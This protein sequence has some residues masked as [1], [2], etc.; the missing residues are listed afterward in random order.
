M[1]DGTWLSLFKTLF[2]VR[3]QIFEYDK[4]YDV[5][6]DEELENFN[7]LKN[8]KQG[9]QQNE[10]SIK[11]SI[12]T[13]SLEKIDTK[14]SDIPFL[15]EVT[16]LSIDRNKERLQLYIPTKLIDIEKNILINSK[17]IKPYIIVSHIWGGV[18]DNMRYEFYKSFLNKNMNKNSELE[19]KYYKIKKI[20]K[21]YNI[22]Y[23]WWDILCI[24]YKNNEDVK[25]EIEKMSK[26]YENAYSTFILL[27][28]YY[29]F[30]SNNRNLQ[31]KKLGQSILTD[32]WCT[33]AWTLQ[34]GL[35]SWRPLI[36]FSNCAV[37]LWTFSNNV[38]KDYIRIDNLF[39]LSNKPK[40]TIQR[41]IQ[42]M[43][44]RDAK[45]EQDKVF[46]VRGLLIG[47]DDIKID[48]GKNIKELWCELFR[49]YIKSTN[50]IGNLSIIP[51][52]YNNCGSS[53]MNIGNIIDNKLIST[54]MKYLNRISIDRNILVLDD[55]IVS[56]ILLYSKKDKIIFNKRKI[57]IEEDIYKLLNDNTDY[58]HG[59][60]I[61]KNN[62]FRTPY[63]SFD[64]TKEYNIIE[65]KYI[66]NGII[67]NF[68]FICQKKK[69]NDFK[70]IMPINDIFE[71]E[72]IFKNNP[73][74]KNIKNQKVNIKLSD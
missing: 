11:N 46:S 19:K 63:I 45:K 22:K 15:T 32:K 58:C 47:A 29:D 23:V 72:N 35:L 39:Y 3:Q 25:I 36:V 49:N 7:K 10:L 4:D 28:S 31:L 53:W 73:N 34:E 54:E 8:T 70:F 62:I 55:V 20:A 27:E 37:A 74:I 61:T 44:K 52:Y 5:E 17:D 69:F 13:L 60:I 43:Y 64:N 21:C 41:I 6:Y 18:T 68:K 67:N 24:D 50:E 30:N 14:E 33:R 38:V 9:I 1:N 71:K 12:V 48:Y 65:C 57:F 42:E 59:I 56:E 16:S 26:Y 66:S 51:T 40:F 2:D